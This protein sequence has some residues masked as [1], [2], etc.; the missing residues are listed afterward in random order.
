MRAARA[1]LKPAESSSGAHPFRRKRFVRSDKISFTL[2]RAKRNLISQHAQNFLAPQQNN[3]LRKVGAGNVN[4][5][6]DVANGSRGVFI[7]NAR[8]G[9]G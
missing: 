9:L 8:G 7:A 4:S 6:W 1:I 5:F 2:K 3:R